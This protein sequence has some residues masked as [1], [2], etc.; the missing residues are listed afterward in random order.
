MNWVITGYGNIAKVFEDCLSFFPNDRLIGICTK[1]KF[2]NKKKIKIS[3]SEDEIFS[4]KKIDSVYI[5]NLNNMHLSSSLKSMEYNLPFILEKPSLNNCL[6]FEIFYKQF[7]KKPILFYEGYMNLFYPSFLRCIE[8]IKNNEIGVIK[9]IKA[10]IKFS[11]KKKSIF[12]FNYFTKTK[13]SR[14]RDPNKFG[15]SLNDIGCYGLAFANELFY[16]LYGY[17]PEPNII[18]VK[19]IFDRNTKVDLESFS[20]IKYHENFNLHLESSIIS[21]DKSFIEILGTKGSIL[22]NDPWVESDNTNLVVKKNKDRLIRFDRKPRHYYMINSF[23]KDLLL[24]KNQKNKKISINIE[25]LKLNT[26]LL[27]NLRAG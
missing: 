4:L 13:D 8:L 6:D 27:E 16:K 23:K 5:S 24:N 18:N 10:S 19:N 17:I 11:I 12:G 14:L 3:K 1:K 21:N 15:G 2:L 25:K 26:F 7:K 22:F 9:N 20:M